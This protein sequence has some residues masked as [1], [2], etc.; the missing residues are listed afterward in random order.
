[1]PDLDQDPDGIEKPIIT[2]L[3]AKIDSLRAETPATPAPVEEPETPEELEEPTLT[4]EPKPAPAEPSD[5]P[6]EQPAGGTEPPAEPTAGF[7]VEM[8][9]PL[10]GGGENKLVLEGLPQ[11]YADTM[12]FHLKRSAELP[13]V[14]AERDELREKATVADFFQ[15]NTLE[16][17]H[18]AAR[19]RPQMAEAFVESWLRQNWR[20][21]P[22]IIEKLGI[23]KA[24]ER[25]MDAEAKLAARETGDQIAAGMSSLSQRTQVQTYVNELDAHVREISRS[26]G[27][28]GKDAEHFQILAA[29]E[30]GALAKSHG[31]YPTIPEALAVVQALVQKRFITAAP[32]PS[33]APT[34]EK[35]AQRAKVQEKFRKLQPG[36]SPRAKPSGFEKLKSAKTMGERLQILRKG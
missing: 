14:Q 8:P 31:R 5:T 12:K 27:I 33:P 1:M 6:A 26:L 15:T 3:S 16:A 17:M 2:P 7:E 19:E 10:P 18:F 28:T 25:T 32:A 35:L 22:T 23:G 21:V 11:E 13:Q 34:P 9:Q 24:D 29:E 30:V 4:P 36:A 20:T